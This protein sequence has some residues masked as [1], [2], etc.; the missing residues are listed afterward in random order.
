MQGKVIK[1]SLSE[2][3]TFSKNQRKK[4]SKSWKYLE[5]KHSRLK[6]LTQALRQGNV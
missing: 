4:V 6:K 3:M 1:V 2:K 5:Q